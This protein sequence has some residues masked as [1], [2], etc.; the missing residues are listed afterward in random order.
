MAFPV[1]IRRKISFTSLA[2]K[3]LPVTLLLATTLTGL[4]PLLYLHATDAQT[5]N[6]LPVQIISGDEPAALTLSDSPDGR[7]SLH[8]VVTG[9][10]DGDGVDD[11]LITNHSASFKRAVAGEAY[12]VYGGRA[13]DARTVLTLSSA[14]KHGVDCTIVGPKVLAGLGLSAAAGDLNG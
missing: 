11:L 8:R 12:I 14:A 3:K 5:V 13:S 4:L 7:S 1:M 6:S 10:F 9:D 2:V